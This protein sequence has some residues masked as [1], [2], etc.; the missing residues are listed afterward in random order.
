MKLNTGLLLKRV[1]SADILRNGLLIFK[2]SVF[3]PIPLLLIFIL[4]YIL[5]VLFHYALYLW[6]HT[7]SFVYFNTC[8]C[9]IFSPNIAAFYDLCKFFCDFVYLMNKNTMTKSTIIFMFIS[10]RWWINKL[11]ITIC[12]NYI[13]IHFTKI[14]TSRL[15]WF[16]SIYLF[17]MINWIHWPSIIVRRNKHTHTHTHPTHTH[18]QI[19]KNLYPNVGKKGTRQTLLQIHRAFLTLSG[20]GGSLWILKS[21]FA[22]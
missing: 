20:Q 2:L 17:L 9:T 22:R 5:T 10:N 16:L 19:K 18:K 14:F 3:F 1:N 6:M 12:L 8:T 13:V 15:L 11:N 21:V 4:I 7:Y